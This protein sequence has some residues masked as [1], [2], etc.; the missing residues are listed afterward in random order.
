[1]F[2]QNDAIGD[3]LGALNDGQ[4]GRTGMEQIR[5]LSAHSA[6]LQAQSG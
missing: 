6:K 4:I 5:F 1:M 2:L 3:F